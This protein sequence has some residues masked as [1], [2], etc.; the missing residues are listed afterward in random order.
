LT[1]RNSRTLLLVS[2]M[3]CFTLLVYFG[4]T[5]T[6]NGSQP[7]WASRSSQ[8]TM[9]GNAPIYQREMGP[10][11]GNAKLVNQLAI[12]AVYV[13]DYG[14]VTVN[15]T[16]I[17]T[18]NGSAAASSWTY[19]VPPDVYPKLR[20]LAAYGN[21]T[22]LNVVLETPFA[23]FVGL[24]VDLTSIGWLLVGG[25]VTITLIQQYSGLT[26]TSYG[27]TE[28][29]LWFYRYV[30]SPYLTK[31]YNITVTLPSGASSIESGNFT[32]TMVNPFNCSRLS[33][34]FGSYDY[35]FS[36]GP[37]LELSVD[38]RVEITVDG[39]LAAVE[40]YHVANLGPTSTT[41]I[42][43]L[44]PSSILPGSLV[45]S[46][47]SGTLTTSVSGS[48]VTVDLRYALSQNQSYIYYVSYSSS[49]DDYRTFVN[50]LND[51]RLNPITVFN[52]TV[53]S[54]T[55]SLILPPHAQLTNA[56][57]SL[58]GAMLEGDQIVVTY[59][60]RNVTSLNVGSLEFKY[61]DDAAQAF[62]RP[63]LL[64]FGF[65]AIGLIYISIRKLFPKPAQ[66]EVARVEGE[67]ER[68][69]TTTLKEFCSNYE[70]KVALTLEI[71]K[72]ADDRRKGRI[73]KRAYMEQVEH[74]R[75]R[76]AS[77]T[78]SINE[79]KKKL[80]PASKR[81]ATLIRQLDT[82]EEERENA[83]ASL[84]NLELRRRQGK[85]S[86]DVYNRLKYENTKKIEKAT[87]GI[88]SIVI[89]MRQETL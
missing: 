26:T 66:P 17:V 84:E 58:Q 86:G 80:V 75:R 85:V 9:S 65:F 24:R 31:Q 32:A 8:N 81:Y 38:R 70:D 69:M 88:D 52:G 18:N 41:S 67:K 13:G 39:Y 35:E 55:F 49:L 89:E 1:R 46:D 48:I 73:S 7:S 20:Y 40:T 29:N 54:E 27:S 59:I 15:D 51:L 12:R 3:F 16:L 79:A 60:F 76:I 78:N 68:G 56:E 63:I 11:D 64:A 45:A 61:S 47:S 36:S 6:A 71:E 14:L 5:I 50:G 33:L 30:V 10:S 22:R 74:N 72:L 82:Y 43:F 44:V 42:H 57:Q 62:Q 53:D 28:I 77:L 37:L 2:L 25:S 23:S 19:Y 4:G 83:R 21:G 87:S 34:L